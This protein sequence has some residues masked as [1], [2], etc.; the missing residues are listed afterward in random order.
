[1]WLSDDFM[2]GCYSAYEE[3]PPVG[4]PTYIPYDNLSRCGNGEH[5]RQRAGRVNPGYPGDT[6]A[7]AAECTSC[8]TSIPAGQPRCR[9]CPTNHLD[10]ATDAE[11]TRDSESR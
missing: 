3:L 5:R 2:T 9:F 8:R 7:T 10:A 11:D 6:T 1:M 4:E